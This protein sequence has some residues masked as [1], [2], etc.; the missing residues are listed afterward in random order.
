MNKLQIAQIENVIININIKKERT[1]PAWI[2]Y[3]IAHFIM[4]HHEKIFP[5]LEHWL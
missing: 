4:V 5:Y 2:Y 1:N 3:F